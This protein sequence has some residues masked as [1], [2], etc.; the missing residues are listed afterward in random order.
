MEGIPGPFFLALAGA[1]GADEQH[2]A[3]LDGNA[4][5]LL[6]RVEILGGYLDVLI[7]P[8]GFLELG[9]IEQDAAADDAL[10]GDVDC[11]FLGAVRT[12]FGRVEAV[13]HLALV[14]DMAKHVQMGI[15]EPMRCDREIVGAVGQ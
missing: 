8:V 14:E 3:L 9:D 5:I 6:R 12:D 13:V 10:A 2:V 15:R 1:S 4:M 7:E 11:A